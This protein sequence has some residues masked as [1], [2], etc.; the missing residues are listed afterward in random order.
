MPIKKGEVLFRLD[1]RPYEYEVRRLEAA[2]IATNTDLP[3]LE[4]DLKAPGGRHLSRRQIGERPERSAGRSGS[5]TK[6]ELPK[7]CTRTP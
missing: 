4:A 5:L 3:K 6:G 7:R 1:P 2:L